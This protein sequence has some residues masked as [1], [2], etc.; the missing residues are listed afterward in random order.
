MHLV[1]ERC[2]GFVVILRWQNGLRHGVRRIRREFD[3]QEK[4]NSGRLRGA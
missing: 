4:N 1:A 2:D 3:L